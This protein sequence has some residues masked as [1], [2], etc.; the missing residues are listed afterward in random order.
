MVLGSPGGSRIITIAAQVI[1]NV[2]DHGM[3]IQEAVNAPRMHHQWLPDQI[4]VEPFALSPDTA[5]ILAAMGYK[6]VEQAPWGAAEAILIGLEPAPSTEQTSGND[7]MAASRPVPGR[8]YGAHDDRRPAGA[9]AG[10]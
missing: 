4:S 2:V 10:Y 1:M 8:L 5:R 3:N 6:I 9:A 7:A